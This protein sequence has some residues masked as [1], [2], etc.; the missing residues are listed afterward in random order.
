MA[1]FLA[2]PG[3]PG[4]P[5][6]L[7]PSSPV[8]GPVATPKPS[9]SLDFLAA[10]VAHPGS[11]PSA[12]PALTSE[13]ASAHASVHQPL[14]APAPWEISDYVDKP[15]PPTPPFAGSPLLPGW[16]RVPDRPTTKADLATAVS[17]IAQGEVPI[18]KS[19]AD[20]VIPA[21]DAAVAT[22]DDWA[23]AAAAVGLAL[24]PAPEAGSSAPI[25]DWSPSLAPSAFAPET[26][27]SPVPL[28]NDEDAALARDL[29]VLQSAYPDVSPDIFL[30]I[31]GK[32]GGV[33]ATL[34]WLSTV[35]EI[36]SLTS[37]MIEIFPSAQPKRVAALVQMMGGEMSSVWSILSNSHDSP[38]T[39]QFSGTAVQR[40][41]TRS[42]LLPDDDDVLSDVLIASDPL[43]KFDSVWWLEYVTSRRYRLGGHSSFLPLWDSICSFAAVRSPIPPRFVAMIVSLGRRSSDRA[44]FTDAIRT[45]RA[46]PHFRETSECLNKNREASELICRILIADGL[47]TPAATAWLSL[48]S[49][50]PCDDLLRKF[51]K[52]HT[53]VCKSRNKAVRAQLSVPMNPTTSE[54]ADHLFIGSSDE[55]DAAMKGDDFGDDDADIFL[56]VHSKKSRAGGSKKSAVRSDVS[57]KGQPKRPV[58]PKSDSITGPSTKATRVVPARSPRKAKLKAKAGVAMDSAVP[59]PF[60]DSPV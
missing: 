27:Q 23:V 60:R 29:L 1:E 10:L 59:L 35:Q 47:I 55:E 19:Y 26:V 5:S 20:F 24:A 52:A 13:V 6:V 41:I 51:V 40:K 7:A 15:A 53:F 57:V 4:S 32:K 39:A 46:L 48:N 31:L 44:S 14:S 45:L 58:R 38:W 37:A 34:G 16:H 9:A 18:A 33:A 28:E 12:L 21:P 3:R 17:A 56:D 22:T 2:L 36:E 49:L 54:S 25:S 11:P 50:N 43:K 8:L 30:T 42:A